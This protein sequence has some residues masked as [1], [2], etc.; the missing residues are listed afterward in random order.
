MNTVRFKLL[1]GKQIKAS[2]LNTIF[3]K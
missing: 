3:D 2:T 1:I